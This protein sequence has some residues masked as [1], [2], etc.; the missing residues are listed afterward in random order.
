MIMRV[1][2]GFLGVMI[3]CFAKNFVANLIIAVPMP[4][5]V[6]YDHQL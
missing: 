5:A 6:L 2:A 1:L 4:Y 3:G